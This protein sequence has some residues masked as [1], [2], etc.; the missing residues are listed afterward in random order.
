MTSFLHCALY[1]AATGIGAFFLGAA[2]AENVVPAA[3]L[4]PIAAIRSSRSFS[5][6]FISRIGRA[7]SRT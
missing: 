7:A 2:A 1:L 6:C 5:G 4:S 3:T